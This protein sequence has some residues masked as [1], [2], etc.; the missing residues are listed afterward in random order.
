MMMEKVFCVLLR[1]KTGV[2]GNECDGGGAAGDQ[3]VQPVGDGEASDIGVGLGAGAESPS[4]VGLADISDDARG[5]DGRHQQH[6]CRENAVLVR[7]PEMAEQSVHAGRRLR[8][9]LFSSD[10][11]RA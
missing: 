8:Q 4:N 7:G 10:I 11:S 5:H 3:V 2:D 6:G 1:E 9:T